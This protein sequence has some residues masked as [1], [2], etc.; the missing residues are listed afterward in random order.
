MLLFLEFAA[1]KCYFHEGIV[2][3]EWW[4]VKALVLKVKPGHERLVPVHQIIIEGAF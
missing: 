2:W 3:V 4:Y 1:A